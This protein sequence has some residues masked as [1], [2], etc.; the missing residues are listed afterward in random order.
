MFN[1][2]FGV[3]VVILLLDMLALSDTLNANIKANLRFNRCVFFRVLPM[4]TRI[5]ILFVGLLN[6]CFCVA[7]FTK[8]HAWVPTGSVFRNS[9]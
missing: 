2:R 1:F 3:D 7:L 6:V 8:S 9:R 4:T 5:V